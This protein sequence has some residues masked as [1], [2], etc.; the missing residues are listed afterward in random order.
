MTSEPST[1]RE[2][3]INAVIAAYLEAERTGQPPDRDELVRRHPD[4]AAELQSFFADREQ[5][6]KLAAPLAAVSPSS[7]SATLAP[8]AGTGPATEDAVRSARVSHPADITTEGLPGP[9]GTVRYFG[10][11]ELLEE[12]ARG[13]MGVVYKARQVSLNRIVALKMILAGQLASEGDV[14]RFRAEA[15]AAANLDHPNIVPIYEV[16]EHEGQHYFSM[17]YIEGGSLSQWIVDCGLRNADWKTG[18]QRDLARLMTTVARAV[19]HA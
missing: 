5:F 2:Q 17:K 4:L 7:E 19:H 1:E 18:T 13:G 16:D 9:L 11:Y 14:Q 3:Q 12:I 8:S 6:Q 10:D 15:E